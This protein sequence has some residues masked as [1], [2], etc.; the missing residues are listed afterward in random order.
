M[1]PEGLHIDLCPADHVAPVCLLQ[2]RVMTDF[3]IARS[4]D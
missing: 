2:G 3:M 1:E 4:A